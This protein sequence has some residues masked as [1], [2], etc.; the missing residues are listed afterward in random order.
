[1]DIL[2]RIPPRWRFAFYALGFVV[3]LT[4]G[5]L[6]VGFG[7]ASLPLPTWLVVTGKV[8]AFVSAGLG[9]T[10]ASNVTWTRPT[11]DGSD[12]PPDAQSVA[13]VQD[14]LGEYDPRRAEL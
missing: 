13:G 9:L 5:A 7:A 12:P 2:T 1:M 8:W 11:D 6:E 4:I 10:A 3:G 14:G